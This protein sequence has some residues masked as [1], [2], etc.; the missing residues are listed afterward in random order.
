[1]TP[2][3]L[4]TNYGS[5]LNLGEHSGTEFRN[6]FLAELAPSDWYDVTASWTRIIRG[7]FWLLLANPMPRD[8]QAAFDWLRRLVASAVVRRG[9]KRST[10]VEQSTRGRVS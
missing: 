6:G 7:G 9:V 1:M 10:A 4:R 3:D 8:T 5:P 2:G